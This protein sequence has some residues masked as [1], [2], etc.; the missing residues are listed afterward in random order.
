M[1]ILIITI[2]RSICACDVQHILILL[3]EGI[4]NIIR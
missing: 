2:D 1:R 3:E 4:E